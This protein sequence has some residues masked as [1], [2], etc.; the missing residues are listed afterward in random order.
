MNKSKLNVVIAGGG[1]AGWMTASAL[2]SQLG[3]CVN[4]TLVESDDIATVGVGEATIPTLQAFHM[5]LQLDEQAFIKETQATF[6]LGIQFENWGNENDRYIHSFGET[7]RDTWAGQFQHFWLR[8]VK[9]GH[10]FSFSDFSIETQAALTDKFAITKNPRLSY[11]YHLDA[12]LYAQYLRKIA[13][14]KDVKRVEG[15]IESVNLDSSTGNISELDLTS[16]ERIQGDLFID[17]TGFNALLL[18]KALQTDF[19]D[20]SSL[21][22]CD[23]AVTVRTASHKPPSPYTRSI[24]H[25]AGWMWKIPLQSRT[26][27]GLVYSSQYMS[28]DEA[29]SKLLHSLDGEPLD[30]PRKLSFKPGKRNKSWVKNCVAIGLSSGFIEPL[31][32]TSIHLISSSIIRLMKMIPLDGINQS[33]IEEFNRQTEK[34]WGVVRDFVA[35]HYKVTDRT[36]SDFWRYC[37][38]MGIPATLEN[39]IDIYRESARIFWSSEELFTVN[40]WNQVMLGQGIQPR[41]YHPIADVMSEQE[42]RKYIVGYQ[43]SIVELVKK[44]PRHD[45]L[46]QQLCS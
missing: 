26:G 29:K 30:E 16:G 33:E 20:W 43:Q 14:Q 1:T 45:A 4:I 21:F 25:T 36:D 19:E 3:H 6:K 28:D 31:E 39:R 32:S 12:G 7:G 17:C 38:N 40:S 44:L 15:K 27:N 18:G 34:E 13:E 9:E 2:A 22:L 23:R 35:L 10:N 41:T 42:L 37:K 46:I 5:L 8:S 24:A 11:A